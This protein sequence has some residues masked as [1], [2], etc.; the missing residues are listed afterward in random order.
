MVCYWIS[1]LNA[2]EQYKFQL[3]EKRVIGARGLD[4][5]LIGGFEAPG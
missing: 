2:E 3:E 4:G 5:S 1:I